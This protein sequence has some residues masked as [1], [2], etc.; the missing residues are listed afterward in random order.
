MKNAFARAAA[1]S[2]V[3]LVAVGLTGCATGSGSEAGGD[4]GS[5]DTVYFGVS[6]A[7]TG[8]YAQYGDQFKKAFDLAVKEVNAD[9]GIDGKKVALKYEDSQSDPKQ[10]VTVAQKFVADKDVVLAF[11]DYASSASIPASPIYTAGKLVQY[12]YN[13]SN[14]D[15]TAKGTE[16]QWSTAI[17]TTASYTWTADYIKKQG[18]KSVGV[19]YLNTADWGIP[20]YK[21]FEA[22]A[23]KIG[24]KITDSEGVL[25]SSDD[26]RPS[27]SKIV[28]TKPDAIVH[29]GYGPDAAKIVNQLRSTGYDGTFYGGQDEESFDA[30]PEAEGSVIGTE[31]VETNPDAAVQK[32]VKAFK[33]AYPSEEH[34]TLFEA[35]AYDALHVAVAAAKAGGTTREGILAG[36][37]KLEGVPSVVY[38]AITFDQKTRRVADPKLTPVEL[39]DGSWS[40]IEK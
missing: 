27:L 4:A 33:K 31:F 15:F 2:I 13:N 9:G 37:K 39:K 22:E 25:D 1:V 7:T 38:G 5:G 20:A 3:A 28:A 11:G 32:F 35:G 40:A 34:V 26:Y 29:V 30:T 10:S 19:T 36:F 8:Q 16:Y 23:K 14:P 12:G 18:V 24:L 21:A 6:S 17:T